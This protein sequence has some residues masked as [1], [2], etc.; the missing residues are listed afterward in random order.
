MSLGRIPDGG[1]W[2]LDAPP[3]LIDSLGHET[4]LHLLKNAG[5]LNRGAGNRGRHEEVGRPAI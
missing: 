1:G 2:R 5:R 3:P 4:V